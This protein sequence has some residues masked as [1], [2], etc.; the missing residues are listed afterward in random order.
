MELDILQKL[1][2]S[3]TEKLIEYINTD[4]RA[5][6]L[7]SENYEKYSFLEL[8][9]SKMAFNLWLC[10]D[11]KDF[12][13]RGFA[14][15]LIEQDKTLSSLE[16]DIL[17]GKLESYVTI[18]EI[19]GFNE[20]YVTAFDVLSHAEYKLL[21]P[22]ASAIL[23]KGDYMLA[24][25]GDVL[26]HTRMIGEISFIPRTV[27]PY[28]VRAIIRKRNETE[29]SSL[30]FQTFLKNNTLFL[31][32]AYYENVYQNYDPGDGDILPIYQ[33]LDEFEEYML[34]KHSP[35]AVDRHLANL[36]EIYE[37]YM[38]DDEMT[39]KDIDQ[40]DL[41][42]FFSD[43]ID[44]KFI[45]S[46]LI[47]KE[48]IRTLREYLNFLSRN[49][50]GYKNSIEELKIISQNRFNLIK[51]VLRQNR[52]SQGDPLLSIRLRE[53]D[54]IPT[55]MY[56][57]DFDRFLLY[58]YE[59]PLELTKARKSIKKK[60]YDTMSKFFEGE[61]KTLGIRRE[62][63]SK[64]IVQFFYLMAI[65][66]KLIREKDGI[67][68]TVPKAEE[69]LSL[70]REDKFTLHLKTFWQNSFIKKALDSD[71]STARTL[72]QA[73]LRTIV[74]DTS[75]RISMK[76]FELAVDASFYETAYFLRLL[77]FMGLVHQSDWRSDFVQ[78]PIGRL[79]KA[80]LQEW[81]KPMTDKVVQMRRHQHNN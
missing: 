5:S 17:N 41:E 47:L 48:Y 63:S 57:N 18:V 62:A 28:F 30:D 53:I 58:I 40:I 74:P 20:P 71:L 11:Y 7:F 3:A 54:H 9:M 64:S 81:D 34:M 23:K 39:L 60:D 24:R 33:E 75:L 61:Y 44:E 43:G 78:S 46:P 59:D 56:L 70:S 14:T 15:R 10:C 1:E 8:E 52:L 25:I 32:E 27:I 36:I 12:G 49:S 65:S 72:K 50:S 13:G 29:N 16:I 22:Q 67:A 26:G 80:H 2:N 45:T 73:Y 69:Y 31:Y 79:V 37:Y 77:D 21:E 51:E 42:Q 66:L 35:E 68:K 6:L 76:G 38:S 4:G 55:N 19:K